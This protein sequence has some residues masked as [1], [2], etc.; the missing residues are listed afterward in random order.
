MG[1]RQRSGDSSLI[2]F[3]FQS[4]E[5]HVS[6]SCLVKVELYLGGGAKGNVS[7]ARIIADSRCNL[8]FKLEV[9]V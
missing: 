3:F 5:G 2:D 7:N 9:N 4:R 1:E 6:C 8:L